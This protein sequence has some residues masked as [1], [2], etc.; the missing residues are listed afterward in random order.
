MTVALCRPGK[1]MNS[2]YFMGTTGDGPAKEPG[3][4]RD[5]ILKETVQLA[6]I[7]PSSHGL[8]ADDWHQKP[9]SRP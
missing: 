2:P 6:R 1:R 8:E 7:G 5:P 4:Y 3:G 9:D